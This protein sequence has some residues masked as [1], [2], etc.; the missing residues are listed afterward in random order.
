MFCSWYRNYLSYTIG[1]I[2]EMQML[3]D[4]KTVLSDL[5]EE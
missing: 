1:V 2:S 3:F 5:P 4:A